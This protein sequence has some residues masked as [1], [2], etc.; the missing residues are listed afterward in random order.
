MDKKWPPIEESRAEA[1]LKANIRQGMQERVLRENI[2]A[3][4]IK[5]SVEEHMYFT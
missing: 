4:I 5:D 2:A 3:L 1:E